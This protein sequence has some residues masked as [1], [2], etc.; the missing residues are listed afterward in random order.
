MGEEGM[1]ERDKEG[2]ILEL[3]NR[4]N[5]IEKRIESLREKIDELKDDLEKSKLKE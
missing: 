2:I 1:Q 5:A 4:F 3:E